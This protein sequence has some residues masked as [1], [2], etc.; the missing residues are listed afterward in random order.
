MCELPESLNRSDFKLLVGMLPSS[1]SVLSSSSSFSTSDD[2]VGALL[3]DQTIY[4][5][6]LIIG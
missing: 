4:R 6:S 5:V 2:D 3:S 1:P